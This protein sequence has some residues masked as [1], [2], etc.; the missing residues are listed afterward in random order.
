VMAVQAGEVPPTE[1]VQTGWRE[2]MQAATLSQ[3]RGLL[4]QILVRLNGGDAA[5]TLPP[6]TVSVPAAGVRRKRLLRWGS[7][8]RYVAH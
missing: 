5:C 8:S 3:G 6:L 7:V 1:T 2:V 4:S